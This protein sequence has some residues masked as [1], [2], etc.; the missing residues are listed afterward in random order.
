M[1]LILF[2]LLIGLPIAEIALF[3]KASAVIGWWSVIGL[4]ILTAVLGTALIRVQGFQALHNL[5]G[6]MAEGKAPVEPVVDG[7]FLLIAAPLMMTP[8]FLTDTIG[9]LLL[10]PP[11]RHEIARYALRRLRRAVDN[12]NIRVVRH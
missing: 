8:G 10:V 2:I 7:V 9:F 1:A 3:I 12:G 6:S 5:R 11:V 4:T